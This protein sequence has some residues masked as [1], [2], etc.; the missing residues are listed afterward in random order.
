MIFPEGLASKEEFALVAKEIK[1]Q[2]K[3]TFILANMTEYAKTPYI[4]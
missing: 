4:K 3:D 1:N 2:N